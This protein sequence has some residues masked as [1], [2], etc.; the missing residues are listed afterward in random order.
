MVDNMV[1]N[2]TK[3]SAVEAREGGRYAYQG[4]DLMPG[5]VGSVS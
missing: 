1:N 5:P 4:G 2:R 3:L